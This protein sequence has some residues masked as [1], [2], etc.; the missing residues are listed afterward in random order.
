MQ[1]AARPNEQWHN[2][3]KTI[4]KAYFSSVSN[5]GGQCNFLGHREREV[6]S[7]SRDIETSGQAQ[8]CA[9]GRY[10]LG[11]P[12]KIQD[13]TR[14]GTVRGFDSCPVLSHGTKRDRAEEDILKQEKDV[15]KQKRML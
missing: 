3:A 15:I 13:G 1:L 2:K 8:N 12:I 9:K 4:L 7:L 5:R 11:Q 6:H 10:G 14:E